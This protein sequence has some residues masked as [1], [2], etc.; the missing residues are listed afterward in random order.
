MSLIPAKPKIFQ[1]SIKHL[2]C[3]TTASEIVIL[4]F[5]L[6]E[7]ETPGSSGGRVYEFV[8]EVDKI[9]ICFMF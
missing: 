6:I 2:L 9:T 1:D 7:G 4:G 8:A 5:V 3:V